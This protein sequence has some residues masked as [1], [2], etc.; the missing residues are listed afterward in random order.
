MATV[1]YLR[2]AL[3]R[4]FTS[5]VFASAR[6][7]PPLPIMA[8]VPLSSLLPVWS[9]SEIFLVFHVCASQRSRSTPLFLCSLRPCH[10]PSWL[11]GLLH[12][13]C[14]RPSLSARP[15]FKC[16]WPLI[17]SVFAGLPLQG[18]PVAF[19]FSLTRLP[20][21][22]LWLSSCVLAWWCSSLRLCGLRLGHKTQTEPNDHHTLILQCWQCSLLKVY[23]DLPTILKYRKPW[24]QSLIR[25]VY[26][27][28]L[29]QPG[30]I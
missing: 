24:K 1:W 12:Q 2:K 17:T 9:P 26:K 10:I 11:P 25:F 8:T 4:G 7:C 5:C 16:S 23:S 3:L 30:T 20:F 15:S 21:W 18:L 29:N 27:F 6:L 22:H 13:P 14:S 28:S 19:C